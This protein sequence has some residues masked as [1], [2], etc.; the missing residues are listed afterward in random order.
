VLRASIALRHAPLVWS[1]T[2]VSFIP[3]PGRNGHVLAKDFSLTSFVLKTLE[4]LINNYIRTYSL[5]IRPLASSQYAYRAYRS[6]DTALHNL[7]S[8]IETQLATGG[9]ALGPFLDIE[10]AFDTTSYTAI[11]GAMHRHDIPETL[12]DW[13]Q[14]IGQNWLLITEA[15]LWVVSRPEG[16]HRAA[17]SLHSCDAL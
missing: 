17:F 12:I 8:K 14:S 11:K 13:T 2:R 9:Y 1:G 16:A 3:K 4:R 6:T 7:V 10:G 5:T 15:K